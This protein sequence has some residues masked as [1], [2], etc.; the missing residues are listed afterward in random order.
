LLIPMLLPSNGLT[1]TGADRTRKSSKPGTTAARSASGAALS[2]MAPL[3]D[4]GWCH[5]T[6]EGSQICVDAEHSTGPTRQR[7]ASHLPCRTG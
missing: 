3:S 2:Q 5:A 6:S 1:L 4:M 7:C